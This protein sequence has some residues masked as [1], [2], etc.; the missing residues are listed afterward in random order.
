MFR[1][2]KGEDEWRRV[3]PDFVVMIFGKLVGLGQ[4]HGENF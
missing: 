1:E 2:A 4:G 3:S